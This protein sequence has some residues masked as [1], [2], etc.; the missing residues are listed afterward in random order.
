MI[1]NFDNL[2]QRAQEIRDAFDDGENTPLRVGSLFVDIIGKVHELGTTNMKSIGIEDLDSLGPDQD[3][4][5]WEPH[6]TY[7]VTYG[8]T[9]DDGLARIVGMLDLFVSPCGSAVTQMFTT[10]CIPDSVNGSFGFHHSDYEV[11]QYTRYHRSGLWSRWRPLVPEIYEAG[12]LTE[13][14]ADDIEQIYSD[15]QGSKGV[16]QIDSSTDI[17]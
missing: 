3:I 7:F 8:P 12:N 1:P 4:R 10:N 2:L 13:L 6:A 16:A 5:L 9:Y 11:R 17:I 15:L 14:T